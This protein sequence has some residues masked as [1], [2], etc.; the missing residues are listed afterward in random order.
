M[1]RNNFLWPKE[2]NQ[3][4]HW[5]HYLVSQATGKGA[6]LR[7]DWSFLRDIVLLEGLLWVPS[8]GV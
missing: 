3:D 5:R 4:L 7:C 2:K 6:R 8:P 1:D